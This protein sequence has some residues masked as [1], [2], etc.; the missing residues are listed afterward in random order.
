MALRTQLN[1]TRKDHHS[2]IVFFNKIKRL[3]DQLASI[4]D[5]LRDTEFTTYVLQGLDVEYDSLV[6][7]IQE[8]KVLIKP[9]ELFQR[10]LSTEQRLASRHPDETPSVNAA[11]CGG[12]GRPGARPATP[13]A[14]SSPPAG[15]KGAAPPAAPS[16]SRPTIVIEN[17]RQCA[18]CAACEA[19]APCQLCGIPRHVASRCHFCFQPNFL[20][21]GNNGKGNESQ[22]NMTQHQGKT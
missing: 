11:V 4:G 5:P 18:C 1:E 20:G 10:L 22:V 3:A 2:V 13:T 9:Q 12:K 17:G 15:G 19:A 7:V 8:C 6:E 14:S 16:Q 21:L